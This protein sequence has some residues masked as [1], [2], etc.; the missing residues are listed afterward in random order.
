M[1]NYNT[2]VSIIIFGTLFL[3]LVIFY[4]LITGNYTSPLCLDPFNL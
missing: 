1:V 2:A 3:E 4:L